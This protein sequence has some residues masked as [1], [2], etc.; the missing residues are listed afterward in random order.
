[1]FDSIIEWIESVL[2]TYSPVTYQ[3]SKI[4]DGQEVIEEVIPA[5]FAGVDW[6]YIATAGFLLITVYSVFRLLGVL[7]DRIGG[8]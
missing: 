1:M 8:K 3:V 7:L 6:R 2:G 5:G 4:L